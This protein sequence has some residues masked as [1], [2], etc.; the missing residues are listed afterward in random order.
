MTF[1]LANVTKPL[2][3]AGRITGR[4]HRIVLDEDNAY[5]LHKATNRKVPL[6]KK[7]NVFVSST[8]LGGGGGAGP[9]TWTFRMRQFEP[10][11][12]LSCLGTAA[13][14]RFTNKSVSGFRWV[15]VP[16]F[17]GLMFPGT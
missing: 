3:P 16:V 14:Q 12:V 13:G 17:T 7:G 2:A 8:W 11:F 4:G 15:G 9:P 10:A 5:I 1:Q 6:Y